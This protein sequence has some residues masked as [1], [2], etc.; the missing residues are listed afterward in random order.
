MNCYKLFI[1]VT[2]SSVLKFAKTHKCSPETVRRNFKNGFSRIPIKFGQFSCKTPEYTSWANMILRCFN[3]KHNSYRYY[4][5][6]NIT[7]CGR[8]LYSFKNFMDDMGAKPGPDYSLDRID[9]NAG[10]LTGNCR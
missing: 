3:P 10:Y 9:N 2:N 5:S 8:W 7:V 1:S 6:K 4:K